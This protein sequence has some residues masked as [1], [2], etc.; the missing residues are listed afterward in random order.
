[1]ARARI[2]E[3]GKRTLEFVGNVAAAAKREDV[4]R[5]T[6]EELAWY[7]LTF[8]TSWSMGYAEASF[9]ECIDFNNRPP[10]YVDHYF[11]NNLLWRDPVISALRQTLGTQSWDD[12]RGQFGISKADRRIIDE[13]RDF[14][15]TNGI[16]IPVISESGAVGVFAPCGWRPDLSDRARSA[17]E[18]V[19]LY[20]HQALQRAEM[21]A[22][23]RASE[24]VSL[25]AR[26]RE[27]MRWVAVGKT[28]DEIGSILGIALA[29]VKTILARAQSK[30]DAASRTY[31]VVQ[32][33][34]RGELDLNF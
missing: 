7:G 30:L 18:L 32:A 3:Y 14:G 33:L 13:A 11:R 6:I 1:M 15:A 16:T 5:L 26:E 27:I 25:T 12:V 20:A 2:D 21:R 34:R 22:A 4:I 28:N 23:R 24:H 17:L 9:A 19:G 29:T 10:D 31:A 8:I